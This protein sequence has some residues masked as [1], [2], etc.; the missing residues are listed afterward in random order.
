MEDAKEVSIDAACISYIRTAEYF[1]NET[2]TKNYTV[3]VE[4]QALLLTM[5]HKNK[6][7]E[8]TLGSSVSKSFLVCQIGEEVAEAAEWGSDDLQDSVGG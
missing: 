7:L 6:D 8:S 1:F 4:I 5:L 3:P 2:K